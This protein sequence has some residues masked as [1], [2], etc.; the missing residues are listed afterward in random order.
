MVCEKVEC[1]SVTDD[2]WKSVPLWAK[3]VALEY[4]GLGEITNEELSDIYRM[5]NE[6]AEEIEGEND[7]SRNRG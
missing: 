1:M 2:Q 4:G 3:M 6:L 5:A 7:F